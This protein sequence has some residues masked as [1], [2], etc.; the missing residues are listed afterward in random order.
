[1]PFSII[2]LVSEESCR[3]IESAFWRSRMIAR[4]WRG[5]TREAAKDA[6]FVGT[7]FIHPDPVSFH[8]LQGTIL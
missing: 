1:V 4:T 7:I 5:A 2:A 8:R 6:D 3:K